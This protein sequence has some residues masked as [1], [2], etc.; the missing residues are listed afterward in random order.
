MSGEREWRGHAGPV[1]DA[2]DGFEVIDCRGCGFRHVVPLPDGAELATVYRSDYFVRDKPTYIARHREDLEWWRL[3][4]RER[5]DALA[6]LLPAGGRR[7]LDV[8]SGPGFF[9]HEA[10]Q[11]G[12]DA[13]GVEP[14]AAACA[15]ARSLGAAVVEEPLTPALA[16]RLGRF[17]A[18]HMAEVL[19]H[20]A[21]PAAALATVHALLAPGGALCV[22]VPNDYSAFQLAARRAR[23]LP[24]W[25]VVP[26]H[27]LN[28]FDLAS[29]TR[30]LERTGF[31]VVDREAT[32]PIDM[33]LLMGDDYVGDDAVGRACHARRMRFELALADAGAGAVRRELYRAMAAAGVGREIV[34]WAVARDRGPA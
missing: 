17:D 34:L 7:L 27:H 30:L 18:A 26:P 4:Y 24:P 8:G 16:A 1:L 11:L 33:F 13:L 6:A 19:E 25:W 5:L 14:S 9:L 22:A 21:D 28:Y 3:V 29:L 23:G 32:F 12:W 15:H 20:L 2:R 31:A 10:A